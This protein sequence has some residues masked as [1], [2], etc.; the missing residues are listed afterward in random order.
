VP[1]AHFIPPGRL[2]S[3]RRSR[4]SRSS[5]SSRSATPPAIILPR[6]DNLE[7]LELAVTSKGDGRFNHS[8]FQ[9]PGLISIP[10]DGMAHNVTIVELKELE[11]KL[12]W[13]AV[14]KIDTRVHLSA[15]IKNT[16]EYA[17]IPGEASVYIDGT[18]TA[19]SKIPAAGPDENFDCSLGLDSSIK[20]TYH[21]L[22]SKVSHRTPFTGFTGIN[23]LSTFGTTKTTSTLYSQRLTVLNTKRVHMN[24][25]KLLD[26][27]PVSEDEKIVVKILKPAELNKKNA[28]SNGPTEAT[29]VKAGP[30]LNKSDDTS[31]LKSGLRNKRFSMNK[32][33]TSDG[34]YTVDAS[35]TNLNAG[36]TSISS[37]TPAASRVQASSTPKVQVVAQWDGADADEGLAP[38]S[39]ENTDQLQHGTEESGL[40][41]QGKMNWLLY[42]IP[43]QGTVNLLLEWEVSAASSVQVY[44]RD[45]IV[46]GRQFDYP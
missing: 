40:R 4:R 19:R 20:I 37:F 36:E 32:K 13:F 43:P 31:S 28:N 2:R 12:L 44:E 34:K 33:I 30:D 5:R 23:S 11:T 35:D 26:R 25:L 17:L 21:P 38:L 27:V 14:P 6:N 1:A 15:K 10:C 16:S 29:T 7:T 22:S 46:R 45:V 41:E 24:A 3:V 39:G 8:V 18:F 9:V 42:D